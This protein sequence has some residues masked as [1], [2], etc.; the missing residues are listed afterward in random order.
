MRK[1]KLQFRATN[2]GHVWPL[3]T[4]IVTNDI[5]QAFIYANEFCYESAVNC[6]CIS[7]QEITEHD[8]IPLRFPSRAERQ[9]QI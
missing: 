2:N 8:Q 4:E 7:I 5:Q 6:E 1:W 9:T 3:S